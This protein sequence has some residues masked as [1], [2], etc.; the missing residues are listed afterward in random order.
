MHLS[1]VAINTFNGGQARSEFLNL[2]R[3]Q[4]RVNMLASWDSSI[5][6][7]HMQ[8]TLDS[9]V[10]SNKFA[11]NADFIALLTIDRLEFLMVDN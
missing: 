3:L 2:K 7:A 9:D 1:G 4:V 11:M 10:F 5:N 6:F 8:P